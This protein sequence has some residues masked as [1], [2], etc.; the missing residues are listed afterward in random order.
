VT[1][2]DDRSWV[3]PDFVRG[4]MRMRNGREETGGVRV[5]RVKSKVGGLVVRLQQ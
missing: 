3:R 5:R 1:V 2:L 4:E